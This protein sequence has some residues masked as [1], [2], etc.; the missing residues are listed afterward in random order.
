MEESINYIKGLLDSGETP[1]QIR[2]NEPWLSAIVASDIFTGES[3]L[4]PSADIV[5]SA[6][7]GEEHLIIFVGAGLHR[8]VLSL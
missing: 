4:L 2:V 5:V 3:P 1:T 6:S 7:P 8:A